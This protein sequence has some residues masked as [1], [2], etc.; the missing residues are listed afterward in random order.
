M[1]PGKGH[2]NPSGLKPIISFVEEFELS[3]LLPLITGMKNTEIKTENK[4][5]M[6]M[7][8]LK[9]FDIKITLL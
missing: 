1:Y 4:I 5:I 9:T 7:K 2:K 8:F 6:I 3:K